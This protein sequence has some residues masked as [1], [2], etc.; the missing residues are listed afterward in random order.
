MDRILPVSLEASKTTLVHIKI[1]F[2]QNQSNNKHRSEVFAD[3]KSTTEKSLVSFSAA[4]ERFQAE[5]GMGFP[6][7]P[8]VQRLKIRK[9]KTRYLKD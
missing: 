6:L 8:A 3:L 9:N 7:E 2:T 5:Q 4:D 1:V